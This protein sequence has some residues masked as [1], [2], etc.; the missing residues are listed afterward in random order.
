MSRAKAVSFRGIVDEHDPL[1]CP[2]GNFCV[3]SLRASL[4]VAAFAVHAGPRSMRMLTTPGPVSL[5]A[6]EIRSA[7][8]FEGNPPASLDEIIFNNFFAT[9]RARQ[10]RLELPTRA[11]VKLGRESNEILKINFKVGARKQEEAD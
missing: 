5:L 9:S 7:T 3:I 8:L 2:K 10:R 11:C 1:D 4:R 6:G